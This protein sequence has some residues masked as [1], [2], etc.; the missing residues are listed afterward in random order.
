[1]IGTLHGEGQAE[2]GPDNLDA[3][4]GGWTSAY[5]DA[6]TPVRSPTFLPRPD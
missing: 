5:G 1:M 2:T 4:G 3:G 6:L